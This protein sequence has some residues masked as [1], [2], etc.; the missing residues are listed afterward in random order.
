MLGRAPWAST[1]EGASEVSLQ[2]A[3]A[4]AATCAEDIE[5]FYEGRYQEARARGVAAALRPLARRFVEHEGRLTESQL[6]TLLQ[7][8]G[9][10]PAVSMGGLA[11]EQELSDLGVVWSV[12]TA[13]WEMG[14]PSFADYLLRRG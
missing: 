3:R 8:L 7:R 10:E 2:D 4:G 6:E 14:I 5:D 9:D 13:V 11:L 12:R 1:P